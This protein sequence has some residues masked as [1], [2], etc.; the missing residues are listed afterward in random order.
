MEAPDRLNQIMSAIRCN[1][2]AAAVGVVVAV[3][4]DDRIDVMLK[5]TSWLLRNHPETLGETLTVTRVQESSSG[6]RPAMSWEQ[7]Q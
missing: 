3:H 1:P 6:D 4:D 2:F 5:P 7:L